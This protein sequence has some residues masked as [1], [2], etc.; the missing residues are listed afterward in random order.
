[1]KIGHYAMASRRIPVIVAGYAGMTMLHLKWPRLQA[2]Q[3]KNSLWYLMCPFVPPFLPCVKPIFA[4]ANGTWCQRLCQLQ[5]SASRLTLHGLGLRGL[6]RRREL[7][8]GNPSENLIGDVV[9]TTTGW[10]FGTFFIFPYIGN[11]H[12]NW[13]SY[14]SEGWPNHQPDYKPSPVITIN[15]W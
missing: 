14:F 3:N 1:M 6:F 8:L 11:N 5:L 2:T 4:Q 10:W 7:S 15:G 9:K 13:L 12:P